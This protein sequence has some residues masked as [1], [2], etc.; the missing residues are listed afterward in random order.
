MYFN[1]PRLQQRVPIKKFIWGACPQT[2]LAS[3]RLCRSIGKFQFSLTKHNLMP[4]NSIEINGKLYYS[5]LFIMAITSQS[6]LWKSVFQNFLC[7]SCI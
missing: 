3:S 5:F 2:P 6:Q 1:A 4:E 7:H